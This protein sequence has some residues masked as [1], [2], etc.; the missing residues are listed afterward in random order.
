LCYKTQISYSKA[1]CWFEDEIVH[2]EHPTGIQDEAAAV[3]YCRVLVR[4]RPLSAEECSE[5]CINS[6]SGTSLEF[7]SAYGSSLGFTFDSVHGS[8]TDQAA[9]FHE[10]K[11]LVYSVL[12]GQNGCIMAYGQTG[13]LTVHVYHRSGAP[14]Q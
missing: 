10:V 12:H 8:S 7:S 11:D 1:K 5:T 9:I 14:I 6:A 3:W 4:L 2:A 13:N